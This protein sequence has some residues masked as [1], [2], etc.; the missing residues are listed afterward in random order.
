MNIASKHFRC[1]ELL[2]V[3]VLVLGVGP[4]LEMISVGAVWTRKMRNL[5]RLQFSRFKI[6][7]RNPTNKA[8]EIY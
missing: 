3:M 5:Y 7:D 6:F 2:R 1:L 4:V 8:S